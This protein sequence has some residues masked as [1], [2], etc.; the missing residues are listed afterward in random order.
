MMKMKVVVTI[1]RSL[2][3]GNNYHLNPTQMKVKMS[4][5]GMLHVHVLHN[6]LGIPM[7]VI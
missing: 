5:K 1:E 7:Y 6:I 3:M 4:F 2:K